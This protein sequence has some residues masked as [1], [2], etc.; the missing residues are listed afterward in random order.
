[1]N[2]DTHLGKIAEYQFVVDASK[3]NLLVSIPIHDHRG[4]D[5]VAQSISKLYKIQVKSTRTLVK[6]ASRRSRTPFY[7]IM[8]SRGSS[9]KELY[10]KKHLDFFAIYIFDINQWFIIPHSAVTSKSI[11]LYPQKPNHK[12]SKYLEA[13]HLIK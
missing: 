4:Y 1:M 9:K 7:R 13:W 3:K 5:F 11:R 2:N 10:E 12:F 8:L 6:D